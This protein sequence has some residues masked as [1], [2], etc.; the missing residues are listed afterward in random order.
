MVG[1]VGDGGRIQFVTNQL[2]GIIIILESQKQ[3]HQSYQRKVQVE[4]VKYPSMFPSFP[5]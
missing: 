1:V 2:H 5:H 4:K 3:Q